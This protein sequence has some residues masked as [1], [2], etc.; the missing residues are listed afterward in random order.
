MT[1]ATQKIGYLAGLDGWRALAILGVL[2]THDLPWK[3]GGFDD[4]K[5]RGFGGY[6]VYLFF[7]ISGFLICTRI[8]E[9]ERAQGYFNIR[10]FY[11]R[12]L[13]RIQPASW[14]Y[15]AAIAVLMLAGV[16][17]ESLQHWMGALLQYQNFLFRASDMSGTGAFT[18]H[19]WTLSIEEHFYVI[20]SLFLFFVRKRRIAIFG[21]LL[22]LLWAGQTWAQQH[23]YFSPDHSDRRTYWRVQ[24]LLCP[25]LLAL[26]VRLPRVKMAVERFLFP[27]VAFLATA[28]LMLADQGRPDSLRR[29]ISYHLLM[30]QWPQLFFGFSLWVIAT[31]THPKSWTTRFLELPPLRFLGRLSYSIYLWHVLFFVPVHAEVGVTSPFLL[32]LSERPYKYLATLVAAIA[33]YYL[34]E[35][36]L[37]RYGHRVAPPVFSGHRDLEV[38]PEGTPQTEPAGVYR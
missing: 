34:I 30:N 6:G 38:T 32:L 35:K 10:S 22:L 8:L 2:M 23:G 13:F 29:L 25:A 16:C 20:L 14:V 12:R 3:V 26:L 1:K 11:V 18:G 9:E 17:H 24:Y 28:M 37:I 5:I 33:S 15:L 21:T 36:P 7:A 4:T 31:V 19:F 27:W